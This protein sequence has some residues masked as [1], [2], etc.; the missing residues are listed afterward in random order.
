M[1]FRFCDLDV[2]Q[3]TSDDP[4]VRCHHREDAKYNH[5]FHAV[6]LIVLQQKLVGCSAES[7]LPLF[8]TS[9]MAPAVA[10]A[11]V[12]VAPA[13]NIAFACYRNVTRVVSRRLHA[14]DTTVPAGQ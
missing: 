2:L 12:L 6:T 9:G 5:I 4:D 10:P 3:A 7:R 1:G 8:K 11:T 13:I 14:T